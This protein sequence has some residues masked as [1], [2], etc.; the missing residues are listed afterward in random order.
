MARAATPAELERWDELILDN[1]DGGNVLQ[2]RAFAETK[3]RFGWKPRYGLFQADK[4]EI[5]VLYLTR[6][7]KGLG[8]LYYVPK[9]P[10]IANLAQL[11]A[12]LAEVSSTTTASPIFMLKLEPELPASD[13][14]RLTELGLVKARDIQYNVNTVIVDLRSDEDTLLSSFKQKTRYNVRLAQR[15]QVTVTA[16]ESTEENLQTMYELMRVT[17]SRAGVHLRSYDYFRT[18]WTEHAHRGCGQLFFASYQGKTLAGAFVTYLGTKALY[19]DGGSVREHTEVQAPYLLQWEVMRW[20]KAR[21]VEEYDLHGTPPADRLE[22]PTHQLHS[23]ARFKLGFNPNVT[24]FVG[25][26]DL[27]LKP[28]QYQLWTKA[29]ERAATRWSLHMKQ[30]L[31]Y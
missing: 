22:D 4:Q 1:P 19:K 21:G 6:Q 11:Q 20:L 23:L 27:P 26:W 31:F 15:H 8:S 12:F 9:G 25:T 29:G 30:Q 10:G 16:A 18:F 13:S 7:I 2:C 24:E 17:T 28:T 5:A 14:T 3:A